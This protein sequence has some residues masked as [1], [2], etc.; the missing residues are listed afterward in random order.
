VARILRDHVAGN[1]SSVSG[2]GLHRILESGHP[3]GEDRALVATLAVTRRSDLTDVQW[4][5]LAGRA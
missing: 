1:L 4:A 2:G 5:V 3:G